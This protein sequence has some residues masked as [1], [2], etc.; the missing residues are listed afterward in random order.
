MSEEFDGRFNERLLELTQD[1]F[2]KLGFQLF[3]PTGAPAGSL[4]NLVKESMK[5]TPK[6]SKTPKQPKQPIVPEISA[7]TK[8]NLTSQLNLQV[9]QAG[10]MHYRISNLLAIIESHEER[11]LATRP[12]LLKMIEDP[13]TYIG[14]RA[15]EVKQKVYEKSKAEQSSMQQED[16]RVLK[17]QTTSLPNRR[18]A[19][20][21]KATEALLQRKHREFQ[22]LSAFFK[23]IVSDLTTRRN[24]ARVELAADLRG[25][26]QALQLLLDQTSPDQ[27]AA[28]TVLERQST[29]NQQQSSSACSS[30]QEQKYSKTMHV[31]KHVSSEK[32]QG[33][34]DI[35][36]I[37]ADHVK[38]ET[39]ASN[40]SSSSHLRP[41]TQCPQGGSMVKTEIK[42]ERDDS[43]EIIEIIDDDD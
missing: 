19:A 37:A 9:E 17:Q 25:I 36:S 4:Q 29:E 40:S 5:P 11:I 13:H 42:F 7:E 23:Y 14:R 12:E 43:T 24:V 32:A 6:A 33:S 38:R 18:K 16:Q 35:V 28:A 34:R 41:N 1:A 31:S 20:G 10:D 27:P 8:D 26:R 22:L 21:S 3:D 15:T 2:C 30:K 39:G